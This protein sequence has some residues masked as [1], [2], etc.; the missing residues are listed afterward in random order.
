MASSFEPMLASSSFRL[1]LRLVHIRKDLGCVILAMEVSID[2]NPAVIRLGQQVLAVARALNPP[3]HCSPCRL[4]EA[5]PLVP[6]DILSGGAVVDPDRSELPHALLE[7]VVAKPH[8]GVAHSLA[9]DPAYVSDLLRPDDRGKVVLFAELVGVLEHQLPDKIHVL[10]VPIVR[11][12]LVPLLGH[13]LQLAG[14]E[15]LFLGPLRDQALLVLGRNAEFA[16][17]SFLDA[18]P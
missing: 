4:R 5:H 13:S 12:I 18:A 7:A 1:D 11:G 16:N 8:L 6:S 3:V 15:E 14:R 9:V 10:A 2:P 17:S